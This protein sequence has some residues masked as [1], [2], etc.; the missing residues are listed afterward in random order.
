MTDINVLQQRLDRAKAALRE[1]KRRDR[2]R[3]QQRIFDAVRRLGL[4]LSDVES[5]LA[6]H[7]ASASV[8]DPVAATGGSDLEHEEQQ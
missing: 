1:A 4:S 7:T 5:L 8:S 3:E 2:E 6:N